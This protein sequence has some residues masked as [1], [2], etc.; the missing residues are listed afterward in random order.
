MCIDQDLLSLP[1]N[2]QFSLGYLFSLSLSSFESPIS[3]YPISFLL[4]VISVIF[5]CLID[6]SFLGSE[7]GTVHYAGPS[8]VLLVYWHMQ[9]GTYPLKVSN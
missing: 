1:H 8:V 3:G 9:Q 6:V 7:M 2:L 4:L 5:V